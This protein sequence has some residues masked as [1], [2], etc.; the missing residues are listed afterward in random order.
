M[1]S[2]FSRLLLFAICFSCWTI[3]AVAQK[4]HLVIVADVNDKAIGASVRVD[5]ENISNLFY[6]NVPPQ[7]LNVS[8]VQPNQVTPEGILKAIRDLSVRS[9]DTVVFYYSGHGGYDMNSGGHSLY[10]SLYGGQSLQ[11]S[12][13]QTAVM[14]KHPFLAVFLR[15]CCNNVTPLPRSPLLS[16][17]LLERASTP[18]QKISP[19]FQQLFF[20][21]TEF[22]VIDIIGAELGYYSCCYP[23]DGGFFTS[24]FWEVLTVQ[25]DRQ[26]SWEQVYDE[27]RAATGVKAGRAGIRQYPVFG[28]Y[29]YW[30]PEKRLLPDNGFSNISRQDVYPKDFDLADLS[31]RMQPSEGYD[32]SFS[33]PEATRPCDPALCEIYPGG[34]VQKHQIIVIPKRILKWR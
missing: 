33:S 30:K 25:A 6:N 28:R 10:L 17:P 14:N 16:V 26:Y 7:F 19:L 18:P 22:E 20:K 27:V 21:K 32:D 1:R 34:R 9:S 11:F 12:E 5:R 24:N 29:N 31:D 8:V 15:D 4:L 13:V 23:N 3:P 2:V